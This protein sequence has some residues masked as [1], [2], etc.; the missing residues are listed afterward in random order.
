LGLT[1]TPLHPEDDGAQ[2]VTRPWKIICADRDSGAATL[3]IESVYDAAPHHLSVSVGHYKL[4]I[5]EAR[6][7]ERFPVV[8]D[9]ESETLAVKVISAVTSNPVQGAQV[10][11]RL[12]GGTTATS[13]TDADGWAEYTFYPTTAGTHT[14]LAVVESSYG[15][16]ED[17]ETM[18]V[19][20]L[21]TNPWK[22]QIKV[23]FDSFLL[24]YWDSSKIGYPCRGA[25]HTIKLVPN[26]DSSLIGTRV[27]LIWGDGDPALQLDVIVNPDLGSGQLLTAAGVTW[28]LTCGNIKDG[29]FIL[30][31]NNSRLVKSLEMQM[32]LGHNKFFI[33]YSKERSDQWLPWKKEISVKICDSYNDE[34]PLPGVLCTFPKDSSHTGSTGFAY[35]YFSSLSTPGPR[36]IK[37]YVPY[38]GRDLVVVPPGTARPPE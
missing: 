21:A 12:P 33:A 32:S 18:N 24:E 8:E 29:S 19:T 23:Q 9:G 25:I 16:H 4:R 10:T 1:L 38:L 22:N 15:E 14:I 20:A 6:N 30:I 28:T 17:T 3:L 26:A 34:A 2:H 13:Q 27:A 35:G 5:G 36:Q 37:V 7:P 11:W 31:A